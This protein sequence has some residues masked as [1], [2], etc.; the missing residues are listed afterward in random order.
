MT[1]LKVVKA[2]SKSSVLSPSKWVHILRSVITVIHFSYL[3][4]SLVYLRTYRHLSHTHSSK[5]HSFLWMWALRPHFWARMRDVGDLPV[6]TFGS[7]VLKAGVIKWTPK[8]YVRFYFFFKIQ[9]NMTFYIFE[10][11]HTYSRTL[12]GWRDVPRW[13]HQRSPVYTTHSSFGTNLPS[14]AIVCTCM[15]HDHSSPGIEK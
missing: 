15:G 9:K 4:V 1:C 2:V 11:L 14:T 7:C 13:R 8:L 3:F 12:P 10:L 5:L 6:L